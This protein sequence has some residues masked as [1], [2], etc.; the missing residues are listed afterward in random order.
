[1]IV[2]TEKEFDLSNVVG[3][4]FGVLPEQGAIEVQRDAAG[5]HH[6]WHKHGVDETL[7]II[8]GALR[9]FW[10]DT[11]RTCSPGDVIRLPAGILHRSEALESGAT[12]LIAFRNLDRIP[13]LCPKV[14]PTA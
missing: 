6:D 9:V 7:I 13:A 1:M 10:Q 11:E 2:V 3:L 8:D 12:Y 14:L 4:I 5:K